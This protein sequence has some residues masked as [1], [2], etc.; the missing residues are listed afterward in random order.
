MTD[1]VESLIDQYTHVAWVGGGNGMR[2]TIF[3]AHTKII[4]KT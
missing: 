4:Q 2:S 3:T 1:I